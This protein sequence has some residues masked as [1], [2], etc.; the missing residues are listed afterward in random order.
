MTLLRRALI[1]LLALAPLAAE[2][3]QRRPMVIEGTT[4]LYQRVITRPGAQLAPRPGETARA[5]PVRREEVVVCVA[6]S[7]DCR[8]PPR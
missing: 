1:L 5:R 2:A 4:S 6:R 8:P 7:S 3:Q